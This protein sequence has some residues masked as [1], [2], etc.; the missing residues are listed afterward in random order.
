MLDDEY[1]SFK[2]E[3]NLAQ[4]ID[5]KLWSFK[6]VRPDELLGIVLPIIFIIAWLIYDIWNLY[7]IL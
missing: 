7:D 5:E 2:Q 1:K 4:K 3:Y 6:W